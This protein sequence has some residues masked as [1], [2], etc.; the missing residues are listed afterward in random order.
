MNQSL[1]VTDIKAIAL[2]LHPGQDLKTELTQLVEA[3]GWLAACVLSC[4]GSLSQAAVRFAGQPLG[5]RLKGYF[6]ITSLNGTLSQ[7]GCHLHI[8]ISD[9]RGQIYGGHLL[10]GCEIYTTV[11]LVIGVLPQIQFHRRQDPKTG[12]P[13]LLI[14][15]VSGPHS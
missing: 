10:E 11:E 8:A 14:D 2:R 7:E 9:K 1:P 6:E 13:E 4:V 3:Q 12:Y 15:R 5:M